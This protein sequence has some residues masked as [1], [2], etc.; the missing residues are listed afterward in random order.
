MLLKLEV[1]KA[2]LNK[3]IKAKTIEEKT[4]SSSYI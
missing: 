3:T 1:G 2:L 4:E